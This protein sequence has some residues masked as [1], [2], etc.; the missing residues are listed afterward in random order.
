MAMTE[1]R[2]TDVSLTPGENPKNDVIPYDAILIV[3]FGGPEHR[4]DVL[5]FLENV[6]RGRTVPRERLLEVAEHY[7]H[8][9]GVSPINSQI[10]ELIAAL[11]PELDRH[12]I[13]LP[14]YWGNRNWH[15]MLPDTLSEMASHGV[16]RAL[17]VVHAA[18][19]SYSS[20]RQ[21]REDIARAQAAIG[22]GAPSVD[23]VRVFYNHPDFIA[24]NAERVRQAL[25][26]LSGGTAQKVHIAFTAHSIPVSMARNCQYEHQLSEACR[27]IAEDIDV[28]PDRFALVFQSRSGRPGDPWL[29]PDILDHLRDCGTAGAKTS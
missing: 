17:A 6:T 11:G 23:K 16:K 22:P 29:E 9:N 14:I 20:C 5:P 13:A 18:Y 8:F 7:Y 3:G 15:P 12:G 21:Y 24:A 26:R 10:R 19:S 27:L 25:D 4:D 1:T 2:P 28:P